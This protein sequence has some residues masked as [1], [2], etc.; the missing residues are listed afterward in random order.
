[1][2]VK[3]DFSWNYLKGMHYKNPR[4]S[5]DYD[6]FTVYWYAPAGHLIIDVIAVEDHERYT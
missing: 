2:T 5:F 6:K 4:I 1:M 3:Q